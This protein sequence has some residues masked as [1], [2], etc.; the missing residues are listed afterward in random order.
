VVM[1]PQEMEVGMEGRVRGGD[2]IT[3]HNY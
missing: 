1:E 2:G 3:L